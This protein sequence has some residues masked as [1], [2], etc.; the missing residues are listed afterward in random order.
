MGEV[1]LTRANNTHHLQA[2]ATARHHAALQRARNAIK[3][4]NR[5]ASTITFAEVARTAHVS[6]GW[7]Y[8]QTDLRDAI[9]A[10]RCQQPAA[11]TIPAAHRAS[12]ESLHQRL[13]SAR[14]E[15]TRLRADNAAMREQL[16]R[17]PR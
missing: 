16:A 10:L 1:S 7:L 4:L 11:R 5:D 6:R 9:I 3:Q 13:E 14:Q 2:A 12:S 17:S 15:I 8:N